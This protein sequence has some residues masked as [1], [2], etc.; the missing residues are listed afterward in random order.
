MRQWKSILVLSAALLGVFV[1][2][3]HNAVAQTEP[4]EFLDKMSRY[5]ED[6]S[7]R[8]S[9]TVVTI[10]VSGYGPV[11]GSAQG[12]GVFAKKQTGGSGVIVDPNGYIITNAH[13]VTGAR[14][15]QVQLSAADIDDNPGESLLKSEGVMLGAQLVGIDLETDLALLK[16]RQTDL[17][18]LPCG[19]SDDLHQGQ[20]GFAFGSPLGLSNSVSMGVVSSVARQLEEE[21]PMVY[22]QTDASINP[23]NSG[24]PLVNN[25]GE[26]IGINTLILSQSGGSEG[27]GFAAPSNIVSTVYK[28][29]RDQGYVRRGEIGVYAQTINSQLSKTMK[30]SRNWG[31]ILGDVYPG[32]PAQKAG[33][34]IADIILTVDGKPMENARQFKVNLYRRTVGE[35]ISI[36]AL[37]GDERKNFKVVIIERSGDPERFA[38]LVSPEQNLVA[39]LG[40]LGIEMDESIAQLLPVVRKPSGVL[41]AARALEGLYSGSALS[42]GDIIHRVNATEIT[43]LQQLRDVTDQLV[44]GESIVLQIERGG[45]LQFQVFSLQ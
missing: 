43:T 4:T 26:L 30:L 38:G 5:F 10:I 13:V 17:P 18:S 36:V 45:R 39:K 44:V 22:I 8:I 32:S 27:I 11:T 20:M 42:P 2:A 7:D 40:I 23:G 28:Q 9:P 31:V 14:R 1:F 19:N 29:L 33:L 21:A 12:G 3:N 15:I 16:V 37:R 25:R 41:V 6:L 24:G 34:Q 35:S